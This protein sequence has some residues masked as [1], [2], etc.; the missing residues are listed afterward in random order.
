MRGTCAAVTPRA[1]PPADPT[2]SILPTASTETSRRAEQAA[3][4]TARG[5]LGARVG[6]ASPRCALRPACVCAGNKAGQG[7]A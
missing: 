1:A 3:G 5:G 7:A 2:S 6:G 4:A